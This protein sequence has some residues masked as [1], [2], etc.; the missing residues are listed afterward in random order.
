MFCGHGGAP[1]DSGNPQSAASGVGNSAWPPKLRKYVERAF[2]MCVTDGHRLIVETNLKNLIKD[3]NATGSL[4]STNWDAQAMPDFTN[5]GRQRQSQQQMAM[6]SQLQQFAQQGG[7]GQK[8]KKRK[9]QDQKSSSIGYVT[10][11]CYAC[12]LPCFAVL[13]NTYSMRPNCHPI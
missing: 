13:S 9:Q 4:W 2:A 8:G 11:C 12:A 5:A 7:K 6:A 1:G 3:A 10:V